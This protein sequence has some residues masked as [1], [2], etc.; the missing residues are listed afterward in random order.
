MKDGDVICEHC[1]GNGKY[2]GT[3]SKYSDFGMVSIIECPKCKGSGICDWVTNIM[4]PKD[5]P[6]IIDWEIRNG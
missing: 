2:K 1:G 5:I 6:E 4:A 3:G